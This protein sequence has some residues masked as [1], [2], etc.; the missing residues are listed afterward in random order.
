MLLAERQPSRSG[1]PGLRS[2]FETLS[3]P[4]VR[5]GCGPRHQIGDGKEAE[6]EAS[7]AAKPIRRG[8]KRFGMAL[9]R[10]VV[11]DSYWVGFGAK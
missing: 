9:C 5:N 3:H 6:P 10:S 1:L 8:G 2:K 4:R 11:V 7:Q